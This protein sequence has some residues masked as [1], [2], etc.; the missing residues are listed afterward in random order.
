MMLSRRWPMRLFVVGVGAFFVLSAEAANDPTC[1]TAYEQTQALRKESK[2]R[3]A[4]EQAMKCARDTCPAVLSR[5]CARWFTEIE[6]SI[7]SIVFDVRG[8]DGFELANVRVSMDGKP[9]V[10]KLDGKSVPIDIG[11]HTFH[12][13]VVG[14]RNIAPLERQA[15]IHEG[16]KNRK[17][18]VVL[19]AADSTTR[20]VPFMTY[21]FG[22]VAIAALGAGGYF[23]VSGLVKKGDLRDCKPGCS[24]ASVNDVSRAFGLADI[25]LS[26]G[27]ISSLAALY[28]YLSRPAVEEP[29]PKETARGPSFGATPTSG[30]VVAEMSVAF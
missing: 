21:V 10:E 12:F 24:A 5:D 14:A 13:E 17:I 29:A 28:V 8:P 7:P 18:A 4:R 27:T 16:D 25:F 30:G 19:R 11:A 23:A 9:L 3:D 6:Q 20:P 2:L 1:I 15:I 26:A 22:G